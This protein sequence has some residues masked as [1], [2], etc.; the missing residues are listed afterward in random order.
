MMSQVP[1]WLCAAAGAAEDIRTAWCGL[2]WVWQLGLAW[3]AACAVAVWVV[4][5]RAGRDWNQE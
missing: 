2:P 3:S 1:T 5:G 4:I